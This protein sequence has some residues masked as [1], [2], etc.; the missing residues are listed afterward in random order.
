VLIVGV[1]Y[2]LGFVSLLAK[3]PQSLRVSIPGGLS[4]EMHFTGSTLF[5]SAA[6]FSV[7]I[8]SEWN[9]MIEGGLLGRPDNNRTNDFVFSNGTLLPPSQWTADNF[10]AFGDSWR[11]VNSTVEDCLGAPPEVNQSASASTNPQFSSLE[12]EA[13]ATAACSKFP[14][15]IREFCIYDTAATGDLAAAESM[16][17][18][19]S[20]STV[21]GNITSY[22]RIAYIIKPFD[23]FIVA[24][25]SWQN[26][27]ADVPGCTLQI[28]VF[29]S[30]DGYGAP[31]IIDEMNFGRIVL[32]G[33]YASIQ[34]RVA[35]S[36]CNTTTYSPWIDSQRAE[37]PVSG[38]LKA[39]DTAPISSID[40]NA[41]CIVGAWSP[42]SNCSAAYLIMVLIFTIIFI[43][44]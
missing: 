2:S 32:P 19:Q 11:V 37:L 18:T 36:D 15:P 31:A 35:F 22:L 25:Y 6:V 9:G 10:A 13:A 41:R 34:L 42:W 39:I 3:S 43:L 40:L 38:L 1:P 8:G 44:Y 20:S 7:G 29:S 21:V 14:S 23:G 24:N 5:N 26:V 16:A 28:R 27:C 4:F 17:C 30:T 12:L 33:T